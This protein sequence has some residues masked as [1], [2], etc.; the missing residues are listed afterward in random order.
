[1]TSYD[2]DSLPEE[3]VFYLEFKKVDG[4]TR[5][6]RACLDND[7]ISEFWEPSEKTITTPETVKRVFD[8]DLCEWRSFRKENFVSARMLTARE[9]IIDAREFQTE[10]AG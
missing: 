7:L 6:M 4:T 2:I 8:L 3:G 10:C 9:L 1:M 5:Y